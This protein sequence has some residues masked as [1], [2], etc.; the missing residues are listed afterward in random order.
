QG[1]DDPTASVRFDLTPAGFHA[2]I[3]SISGRVFID[4]YQRG[5][6]TNH[7]S[8]FTRDFVKEGVAFRCDVKSNDE[9]PMPAR[10]PNAGHG[11]IGPLA[12]SG[13]MLR[14]YRAAVAADGEYTTFICSPNPAAV[15]C[16]LAGVMTSMNRVDG[17]YE[18]ELAIRMVLV[19]NENLIIYTDAS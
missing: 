14:T 16:G 12:A 4:P 5:D 11:S 17:I 7:I 6:T 19:A 13:A 3:L 9:A 1:L 2:Q 10:S 15:A 8:Y 18:K